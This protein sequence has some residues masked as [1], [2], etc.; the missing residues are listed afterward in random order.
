MSNNNK[1]K[2]MFIPT[3]KDEINKLDWNSLDIILITGDTY[4]DSPFSG[5]ALIGKILIKA[6][7]K[8]GIIAQPELNSEKD[9][10]RLGEPDLFW[11]VTG[12]CIDSMVANKTATLK[13]RKSDDYTP[14]GVNNKRP[15]RAVIQYTNLIKANF[16]NTA[17]IVLGGL[18]ASL[19]RI[20]HYDLW[21]KKIRRS[22]LFDSKADLLLYGMA[23]RSVVELA[24]ALRDKKDPSSLRG[25]CYISNTPPADYL[26]LPDVQTTASD[27]DAFIEMF[28][29]F[30]ENNDP[31]TAKG[32]KQKHDTRY[33][34]QTPPPSYLSID[35]LDDIYDTLDF[36]REVH[37]YYRK[38]GKT[39]ALDT[40]RFSIATHRG[41]YGECNFCSIAVHQGRQI[42]WRSKDSIIKEA[43]KFTKHPLFKGIINNV[44]GPTANM[45]G[46]ECSKKIKE[47][48]CKNKRCIYPSICPSLNLDHSKYL[49][50]LQEIRKIP[51]IKKV[52]VASG[53]RYDLLLADKNNVQNYIQEIVKYHTSGQLKI[54]PEHSEKS[55]LDKMGKPSTE[56]LLEFRKLFDQINSKEAKK[57]FLTYYIIAAHPGC[58]KK[59]MHKLRN[60]LI[61]KLKHIP[62]Q[63]Q[64]FTPTPS[65]YS[66]LMYYTEKDPFTKKSIFV[67]KNNNKKEKQKE[68]LHKR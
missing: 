25:L 48:A 38:N 60:F 5:V 18:E 51:G 63:V 22:I 56:S 31:Q 57:Q 44:G 37:P 12:G 9:I 30:Y 14:G 10:C 46:F 33:L 35:E 41:C 67:E 23:D 19:R 59:D 52:F 1:L 26:T 43:K 21:S 66:T 20:A 34:V 8:V 6:D 64:V 65:T 50:L 24:N 15:D 62:Q 32:L 13:K 58:S 17:P 49:E 11:G 45:Y 47:G 16:K 61:T 36:E 42:R 28:N 68:I 55:V 27:K 7:F 3:T 40:I 53:I 29:I 54:A 2:N 39:K 4:I